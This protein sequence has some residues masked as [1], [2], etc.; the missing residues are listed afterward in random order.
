METLILDP[1]PLHP[2]G[3]G[4][5]VEIPGFHFEP[6]CWGFPE[7][8]A[9]DSVPRGLSGAWCGRLC[10]SPRRDPHPAVTLTRL[11]GDLNTL[12]L[13]GKPQQR[14]GSGVFL[15]GMQGAQGVLVAKAALGDGQWAL[16]CTP[17]SPPGLVRGSDPSMVLQLSL[18]WSGSCPQNWGLCTALGV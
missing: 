8:P 14:E 2:E 9:V 17:S 6:W 18:S 12:L 15:A 5:A 11:P 10:P 7:L 16:C 4:S 1:C 13:L 3:I